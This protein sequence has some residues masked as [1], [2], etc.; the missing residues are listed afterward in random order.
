MDREH[1]MYGYQW[2]IIM[3]DNSINLKEKF[4]I[5]HNIVDKTW[6]FKIEKKYTTM[7]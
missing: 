3:G 4:M 1:I 5:W 7:I 2:M 6:F